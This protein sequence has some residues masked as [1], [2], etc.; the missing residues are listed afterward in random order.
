[1]FRNKRKGGGTP[2]V[3]YR[4]PRS[5]NVTVT[6]RVAMKVKVME[7]RGNIGS[8]ENGKKKIYFSLMKYNRAGESTVHLHSSNQKRKP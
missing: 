2:S 3:P 6:K 5:K 8:R 4:P 1:V 7:K